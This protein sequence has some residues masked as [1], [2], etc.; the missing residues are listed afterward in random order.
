MTRTL[1]MGDPQAPFAKVQEILALHRA[2]DG[3][4]IASDVV[5]VS[6]GDHFDYDVHNPRVAS[7]EGVTLLRWLASHDPTHGCGYVA[8]A[9]QTPDDTCR[10][11]C[12][13]SMCALNMQGVR[14][15]QPGGCAIGRPFLVG[16]EARTA[17]LVASRDW[18]TP[19]MTP[20]AFALSDA[21]RGRLALV[22]LRSR[23][24]SLRDDEPHCRRVA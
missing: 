4:R 21:E 11:A 14:E 8:F 23:T 15:C 16:G 7:Q 24:R 17:E 20:G 10:V 6:I 3:N 22:V 2:L 1:V 19:S 5:L 9:C 12:T 18:G 13:E